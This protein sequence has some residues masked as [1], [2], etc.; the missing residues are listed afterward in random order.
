MAK[1]GHG[2]WKSQ[3]KQKLNLKALATFSGQTISNIGQMQDKHG[4]NSGLTTIW[5]GFGRFSTTKMQPI[6]T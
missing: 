4:Q 2:F 3:L 5:R 6:Y 1:G